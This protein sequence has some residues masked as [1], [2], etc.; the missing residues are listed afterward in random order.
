MSNNKITFIDN[1]VFTYK[2]SGILVSNNKHSMRKYK[3]SRGS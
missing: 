2:E 1:F 3:E